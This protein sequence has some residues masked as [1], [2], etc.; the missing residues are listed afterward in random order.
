MNEDI[1]KT[2][3]HHKNTIVFPKKKYFILKFNQIF[4]IIKP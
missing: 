4:I 2:F 3:L 1:K